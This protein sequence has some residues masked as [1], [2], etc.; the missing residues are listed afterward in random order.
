M[1]RVSTGQRILFAILL[2]ACIVFCAPRPALAAPDCS[3]T[4]PPTC[5][6]VPVGTSLAIAPAKINTN[7]TNPSP[8]CEIVK[9]GCS[10][11]VMVPFLNQTEWSSFFNSSFYNNPNGC[12]SLTSCALQVALTVAP[13]SPSTV[14]AGGATTLNW[15]ITGGVGTVTCTPSSTDSLSTWPQAS[16]VYTSIPSTGPTGTASVSPSPP[17]GTNV[18][19]YT[20]SCSDGVNAG[21][22]S[23]PAPSTSRSRSP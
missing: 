15:M 21:T 3:Q 7:F 18:T 20:L 4:S 5:T 9:N 14:L 17:S 19:T 2:P 10:L 1:N 16:Y 22:G 12:A 13:G 11:P 8:D 6:Y 23:V